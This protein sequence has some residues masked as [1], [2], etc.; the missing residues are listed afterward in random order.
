M[1]NTSLHTMPVLYGKATFGFFINPILLTSTYLFGTPY[2]GSEY[3][4]S[5]VTAEYRAISPSRI[6]NA[7]A[8]MIYP[9]YR[10]LGYTG[11]IMGTLFLAGL[12]S[13]LESRLRIHKDFFSL[14]IFILVFNSVLN[15]TKNY[16][17]YFPAMGFTILYLL[18]FVGFDRCRNSSSQIAG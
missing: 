1:E 4:I 18:A 16:S 3:L 11:V 6:S 14:C 9:L 15:S 12:T 13:I 2:T 5:Q 10:D 7:L 8:T 17:F